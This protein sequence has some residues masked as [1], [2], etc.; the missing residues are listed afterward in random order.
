MS[1]LQE[2][3]PCFEQMCMPGM[4]EDYKL[5]IFFHLEQ[6]SGLKLIFV[7]EEVKEG[8]LDEF[9]ECAEYLFK[10]FDKKKIT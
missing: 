10:E 4:T 2:S 8:L 3:G 5:S 9:K 7:C 1:Q 6:Y